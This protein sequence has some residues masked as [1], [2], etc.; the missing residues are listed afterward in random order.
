PICEPCRTALLALPALYGGLEVLERATACLPPLPEITQ[1]L[2]E[3]R[4]LAAAL[5][6]LPVSFDLADLRGLH[7][8]SGVV[9]AAYCAG[10]P[11]AIAL[12]GRYDKVGIA[13]GRDRAATGFSLD[14]RE[15][16]RLAQDASPRRA[17]LAPQ[18]MR[19]MSD[20]EAAALKQAVADLR[21][22]GEIV[23]HA[24][25]GHTLAASHEAGCDR[26]LCWRDGRWQ[27]TEL[28]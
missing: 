21:A 28:N 4:V 22:A 24:L 2:A 18:G 20:T 1:A 23:I 13:F 12:G 10:Y 5:D 19:G 14:L 17:I 16:A 8:H 9:F 7:Y 15:L 11:G 3:L 6:G 25:P 27:V 26:Q